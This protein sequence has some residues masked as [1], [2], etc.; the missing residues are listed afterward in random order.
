MLW[1]GLGLLALGGVILYGIFWFIG[2]I[3]DELT[4]S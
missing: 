4:S 1:I 3:L 2:W